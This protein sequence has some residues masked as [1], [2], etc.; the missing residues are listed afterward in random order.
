MRLPLATDMAGKPKAPDRHLLQL[1]AVPVIAEMADGRPRRCAKLLLLRGRRRRAAAPRSAW[2]MADIA[3]RCC[4]GTS[5]RV[6]PLA[7]RRNL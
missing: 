4:K 7:L 5:Q 1:R 6:V 3:P 2:R